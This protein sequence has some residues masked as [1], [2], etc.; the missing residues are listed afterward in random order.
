M[1]KNQTRKL[2]A[3]MKRV[4]EALGGERNEDSEDGAR[5]KGMKRKGGEVEGKERKSKRLSLT[6]GEGGQGTP[7][8]SEPEPECVPHINGATG[9]TTKHGRKRKGGSEAQM[10]GREPKRLSLPSGDEVSKERESTPP[11]S[12]REP[13][14][15]A[16]NAPAAHVE[17][18][19]M[20]QQ[21]AHTQD[22][23]PPRE[24]SPIPE[25][26]RVQYIDIS[27]RVQQE[28]RADRIRDLMNS[29]STAKKRT[30]AEFRYDGAADV[31]ISDDDRSDAPSRGAS[32]VKKVK[33]AGGFE[34]VM[35]RKETGFARGDTDE[36]VGEP[37]R[38]K[39]VKR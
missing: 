36:R 18:H 27:E 15:E 25:Q 35:K 26:Y 19:S 2:Q 8:R 14:P 34:G 7:S 30:H 3:G 4:R 9:A 24:E 10:K 22:E 12:E 31:H 32:P 6:N 11:R 20:P 1:L 38:R 21:H 28:L 5:R 37:D 39:R 16:T 13:Y 29:P 33:Y 17:T 23:E